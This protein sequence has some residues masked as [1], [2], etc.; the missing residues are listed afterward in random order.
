MGTMLKEAHASYSQD[1][2]LSA[3]YIFQ[4]AAGKWETGVTYMYIYCIGFLKL[5]VMLAPEIQWYTKN[6]MLINYVI[7]NQMRLGFLLK[8]SHYLT[9]LEKKNN[10]P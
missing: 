5:V 1:Y 7:V 3:F 2:I 4:G 8:D 9:S 10:L 6:K